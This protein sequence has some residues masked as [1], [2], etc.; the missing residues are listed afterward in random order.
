MKILKLENMSNKIK[1]TT[2]RIG[3]R[4]DL[5]EEIISEFKDGLLE[6]RVK[7]DLPALYI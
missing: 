6:N 3:R 4:I 7:S 1:I 5:A 2:E